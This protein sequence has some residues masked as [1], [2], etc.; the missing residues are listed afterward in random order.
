MLTQGAFEGRQEVQTRLLILRVVAI[1]LFAALAVA[2]WLLQVVQHEK[3]EAWADKNYLR[4]I[5]LRAPRGVLYDRT[6]RVLVENRDSFTIA[7]LRERSA[8]LNAAIARLAEAVGLPEDEVREPI[9]RAIARRD[10]AFRPIPVVQ[11]ASLAQVIAVRARK[12]ELPEVVVQQVPTRQYPA[13]AWRRT[14]SGTSAKS[15]TSRLAGPN[16]RAWKWARS[17]ASRA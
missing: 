7:F 16:S 5:P 3:Y 14:C 10:P 4:T 12:L 2:F 11:H 6:G 9:Q 15:R 1:S 13:K 8:N 17:S